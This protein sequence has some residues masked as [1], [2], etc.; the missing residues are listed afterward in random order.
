MLG[1]SVSALGFKIAFYYGITGL[2][3]VI[4]HRARACLHGVGNF[5]FAGVLPLARL[6]PRFVFFRGVR[7]VLARLQPGGAST[8]PTP[9][10]GIEVPIVIGIG[11]LLLGAVLMLAAM[12]ARRAFLAPAQAR[13]VADPRALEDPEIAAVEPV[14]STAP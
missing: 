11:G 13:E 4:Y 12:G 9:V 14:V 1:D 7:Q 6:R 5:F 8:T 2:A 10:L 3:C